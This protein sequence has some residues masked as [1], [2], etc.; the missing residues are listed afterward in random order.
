MEP[1]REISRA[2]LAS[3][4][5][6]V[7]RERAGVFE[8]RC[9]GWDLMSNRAHA[10]E[11]RMAREA[12]G[13]LADRP[14]PRILIGGLGMGFTLRAALGAL[15]SD[16][17]IIVAELVPE[18]IEWARGPM[19]DVTAGC[20]DDARVMLVNDDVA[21]LIDAASEGYD[22]ILLDVDNG[23]EGLT[24][25]SNDHLYSSHGLD[26]LWEALKVDGILGVWSAEADDGFTAR[27]HGA[28][29]EVDEVCVSDG[30]DYDADTHTLWFARKRDL[31]S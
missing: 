1:W 30:H 31:V 4:D 9:N 16:A 24:R 10:S 7:L 5:T 20:L 15:G 12:L 27:L 13:L 8:I 29:F 22:A 14:A 28:G 19:V 23:P 17:R 3:G 25:Q 6:L 11:E 2:I 26:L 18:I 21:M